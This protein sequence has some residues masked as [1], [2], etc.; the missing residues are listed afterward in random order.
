MKCGGVG[1]R[2]VLIWGRCCFCLRAT[3][4]HAQWLLLALVLELDLTVFGGL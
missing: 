2:G 3:P 1:G 4:S